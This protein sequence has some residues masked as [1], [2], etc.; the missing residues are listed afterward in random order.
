MED[1]AR[2]EQESSE[3]KAAEEHMVRSFTRSWLISSFLIWMQ[4]VERLEALHRFGS[5]TRE[6]FSSRL[7]F[8]MNR[9][10]AAIKKAKEEAM[11]KEA[12]LQAAVE[13]AEK[14]GRVFVL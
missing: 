4:E 1:K 7:H 10:E 14:E 11:N 12:V 2:E 5:L 6:R 13:K 8:M 3:R 9:S